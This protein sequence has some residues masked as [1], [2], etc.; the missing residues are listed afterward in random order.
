MEVFDRIKAR[1][2]GTLTLTKSPTKPFTFTEIE[3]DDTQ[4]NIWFSG[5]NVISTDQGEI[6]TLILPEK[7]GASSGI[8]GKHPNTAGYFTQRNGKVKGDWGSL[9]GT[10]QSNYNK[11]TKKISGTFTV[12][13]SSVQTNAVF[14][15]AG[16]FDLQAITP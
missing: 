5:R 12:N 1:A 8:F 9:S 15:F 13:A 4:G 10:Y 6:L 11:K 16:S 7:D 3:F 2:K 14:E